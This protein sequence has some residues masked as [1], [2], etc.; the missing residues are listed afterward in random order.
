M[1]LN[2]MIN[3]I[4]YKNKPFLINKL[5]VRKVQVYVAVRAAR[6]KIQEATIPGI[7]CKLM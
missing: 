7:F 5:Y 3:I 1:W 4:S 6:K 2:P